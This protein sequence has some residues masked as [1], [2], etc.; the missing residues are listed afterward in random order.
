MKRD[1]IKNSVV[2]IIQQKYLPGDMNDIFL[3][4]REPFNILGVL[5][6]TTLPGTRTWI[7]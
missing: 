2:L 6:N 1:M 7:L 5:W 4:N 3:G